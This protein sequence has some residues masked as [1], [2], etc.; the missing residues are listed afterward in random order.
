MVDRLLRRAKANLIKDDTAEFAAH[1]NPR[2]TDTED[3]GFLQT[4]LRVHCSNSERGGQ[5]RR[6]HDGY[7]VQRPQYNLLR[8]SLRQ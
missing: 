5:R 2:R 8:L 6:N 7:D 4:I 1:I 3:A